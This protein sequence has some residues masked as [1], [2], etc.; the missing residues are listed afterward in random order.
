MTI[1]S[2]IRKLEH[3]ISLL[4]TFLAGMSLLVIALTTVGFVQQRGTEKVVRAEQFQ[5]RSPDGRLLGFWGPQPRGEITL[6]LLG[7]DSTHP[8]AAISISDSGGSIELYRKHRPV[9]AADLLDGTLISPSLLL[10]SSAGRGT[11][12]V[13]FQGPERELKVQL[14]DTS[15]V[16][17]LGHTTLTAERTGTFTRYPVSS[18]ILLDRQ[19]RVRY[20]LP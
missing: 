1:E 13:G 5:L 17:I 3:Q 4:R 18:L 14:S 12:I 6:A 9:S 8:T 2:R 7:H 20:T 10:A 11:L 19:G 16:A 15:G